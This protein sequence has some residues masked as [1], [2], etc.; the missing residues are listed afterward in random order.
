M[1]W[2]RPTAEFVE[3]IALNVRPEDEHEV[4]LSDGMPGYDAVVCSF[5]R[6]SLSRVILGDNDDPLGIT[7]M[8]DNRIWLLG[9]TGLTS[10]RSH[11]WQLALHGREW[12]EHCLTHVKGPIGNHAYSKNRAA[13]RWLQHL[14]FTIEPPAPYGPCAALFCEFWRDA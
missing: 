5:L 6:S 9:T 2:A 13:L 1:K 8:C 10:T 4:R 3:H 7:G 11:R 12:V 14:G